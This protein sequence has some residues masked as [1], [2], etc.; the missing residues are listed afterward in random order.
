MTR[1][2]ANE[3]R[4]PIGFGSLFGQSADRTR[5]RGDSLEW[6]LS[7]IETVERI[8][9]GG[10]SGGSRSPHQADRHAYSVTAVLRRAAANSTASRSPWARS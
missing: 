7:N 2:G 1:T 4:L 10:L 6:R 3:I 5:L 8:A 9:G